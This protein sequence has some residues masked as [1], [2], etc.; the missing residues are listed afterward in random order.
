MLML[1]RLVVIGVM[2]VAADVE[3]GEPAA[4]DPAA[5]AARLDAL[6]VAAES[7]MRDARD[8]EIPDAYE[9]CG[10]AYVELARAARPAIPA[11]AAEALYNAATCFAHGGSVG[12]AV[13]LLSEL[14][15]RFPTHPLVAPGL[16]QSARL[17]RTI[18]F[19]ADAAER[20]E[21]FAAKYPT[22]A[23]AD[24][25]LADAV[26][27]REALGD[28]KAAE[29]DAARWITLFGR[30]RQGEAAAI[31]LHRALVVRERGSGTDAMAALRG[32]LRAYGGKADRAQQARVL[33]AIGEL[34]WDASCPVARVD[35]LCLRRA[36]A[37]RGPR[38][39]GPV[40]LVAV[41]RDAAGAAEATKALVQAIRLTEA[42]GDAPAR[43]IA[44]RAR[45][46]LADAAIEAVAASSMPPPVLDADGR[47]T[48]AS[49]RAQ[50]DW[51]G[52]WQR[53]LTTASRALDE[54]AGSKHLRSAATAQGRAAWLSQHA[55]DT[56]A[57]APLPAAAART[58]ALPDAWRTTYC[59]AI[60]VHAEPLRTAARER[61]DHCLALAGRG[62][63]V[64]EAA[65]C[66]RVHDR[67]TGAV[68]SERLPK[69]AS[70]TVRDL[71]PPARYRGPPN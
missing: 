4:E 18:G 61:A 12:A 16:F 32:W 44:E 31:A 48:M 35:G 63:V 33:L 25:A 55:A 22:E 36:P 8:V 49:A 28:D 7:A 11:L 27:L 14:E 37:G 56:L 71:E 45:L 70:P 64:E 46:V 20:L 67:H 29:R 42:G 1:Q 21:R 3:A 23:E 34:T 68:A 10:A 2:L 30:Q 58:P 13:T 65:E 69:P 19:Y 43:A 59:D 15:H 6:R 38:C 24:E 53:A 54:V 62:A 40:P 17:Y 9:R 26:V 41:A 51:L 39:G 57:S 47:L 66:V 50:T 5:L 60:D 52:G